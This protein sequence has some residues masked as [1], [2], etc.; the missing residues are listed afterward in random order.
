M[1]VTKTHNAYFLNGICI[2]K[3]RTF[4]L[5]V[6]KRFWF[7]WL[8]CVIVLMLGWLQF[9]NPSNQTPGEWF[10]R[11]GSLVVGFALIAEFSVRYTINKLTRGR[12]APNNFINMQGLGRSKA[13][14]DLEIIR[15][16]STLTAIEKICDSISIFFVF[17]GTIV[18]GYGD[19]I[20]YWL[21]I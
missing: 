12:Q 11:T 17:L 14:I 5:A 13:E 20:Y 19:F 1:N 4:I 7:V 18:W 21:S 9:L 15:D 2:P 16:T 6:P 3:P 8:V 10:Q